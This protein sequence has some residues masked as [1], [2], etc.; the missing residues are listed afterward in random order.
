MAWQEACVVYVWPMIA[1]KRGLVAVRL[2]QTCDWTFV[3]RLTTESD[4]IIAN[5]MHTIAS[6][7]TQSEFTMV[8]RHT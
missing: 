6:K 8:R 5:R 7:E 2:R 4:V 1:E 3:S